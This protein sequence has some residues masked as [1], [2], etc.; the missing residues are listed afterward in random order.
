MKTKL[1]STPCLF[2]IPS[3]FSKDKINGNKNSS[4]TVL[5]EGE[6]AAPSAAHTPGM[7]FAL[8]SLR[9]HEADG[10]R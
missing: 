2:E 4:S 5:K 1:L 9:W 8:L 6:K 7:G 10:V 3:K